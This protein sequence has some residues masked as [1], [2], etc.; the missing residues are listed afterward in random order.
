MSLKRE[1]SLSYPLVGHSSS[2]V[3]NLTRSHNIET[4]EDKTIVSIQIP[5]IRLR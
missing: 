5:K 4:N 3:R 1:E 2:I